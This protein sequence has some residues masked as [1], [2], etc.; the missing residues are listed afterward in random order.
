L[1][2]I[3][4]SMEIFEIKE[5]AER[6]TVAP[7]MVVAVAVKKGDKST[8]AVN[9]ALDQLMSAGQTLILLH[10]R[11]RLLTIPT[12]LGN[13]PI[14]QVQGDAVAAYMQE[15]NSQTNVLFS[16]YGRLCNANKV[17]TLFVAVE[18]DD[19]ASAIV[20][21]ISNYGIGILVMGSSSSNALVRRFKGFDVPATVAKNAPNFCTVYT[22]SKNKCISVRKAT[23]TESKIGN[24]EDSSHHSNGFSDTNNSSFPRTGGTESE[25]ETSNQY[26]SQAISWGEAFCF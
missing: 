15:V 7:P 8:F 11:P 4:V 14:S 23:C 1:T 25:S 16:P 22:I 3:S 13:V 24:P 9:W 10:V 6:G 17:K 12:P 26:Y 18:E 21:Q 5:V 2:L 19:V 20:K